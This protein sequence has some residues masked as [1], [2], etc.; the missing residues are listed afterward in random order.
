MYREE[1]AE[2]AA[3]RTRSPHWMAISCTLAEARTP[4]PPLPPNHEVD[5]IMRCAVT[6]PAITPATCP[7]TDGCSS[8]PVISDPVFI[9]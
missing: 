8:M 4:S 5:G 9:K 3:V 2:A 1:D 7:Y 6:T